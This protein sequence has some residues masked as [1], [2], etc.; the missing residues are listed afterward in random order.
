MWLQATLN[1]APTPAEGEEMFAVAH[2]YA[3]FNDTFVVRFS[4]AQPR[5]ACAWSIAAVLVSL[6]LLCCELPARLLPLLPVCCS[7]GTK[8]TWLFI[9]S[10][11]NST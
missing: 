2:I 5:L 7:V 6:W 4:L 11:L 8:V 1:V 9:R 10:A 3:S